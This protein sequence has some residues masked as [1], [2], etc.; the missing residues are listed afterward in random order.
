MDRHLL[1]VCVITAFGVALLPG[2]SVAQQKSIKDQL[3]GTWTLLLND[4]VK[5][6]G[7]HEPL[8]GPNPSGTVIFSPDGHYSLQIMRASLPKFASNSRVKG[9]ADENKAVVQGALTHFGK[10]T[11]N[12]ADKTLNLQ[13]ESS[14]F[15]NWSGTRQKR[16]ITAMAD[17]VL[18][19]TTAN[20]SADPSGGSKAE[21]V[22]KRAK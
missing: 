21:L 4:N 5:P 2:A 6:D 1:S 22:W 14:S 19:W 10:Y 11:V 8:F 3:V 12:D 17:D 13:I 7:S 9:S 15:P 18:T 20:P 16:P